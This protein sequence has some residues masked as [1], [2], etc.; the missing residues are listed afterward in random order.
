[1]K[2]TAANTNAASTQKNAAEYKG[3]ALHVG[4]QVD[5]IDRPL[6]RSDTVGGDLVEELEHSHRRHTV[7]RFGPSL[8]P[9][10]WGLACLANSETAVGVFERVGVLAEIERRQTELDTSQQERH[11]V[12]SV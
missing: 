7:Q 8:D 12:V 9:N 11:R 10:R 6:D 3:T 1:M 5:P 2:V 4:V